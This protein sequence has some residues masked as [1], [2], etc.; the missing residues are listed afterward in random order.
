MSDADRRRWNARYEDGAYAERSH[1]SAYVA[2][3]VRDAALPVQSGATAL[4]VACGAGRNALW[5]SAQ[6][7]DVTGIDI[8]NVAL[9]RAARS[10]GGDRIRWLQRDLEG[11]CDIGGQYDLIVQVRYVNWELSRR[12]PE[13]LTN[14][15]M[16]ICEQHL[17]TDADVIGPGNPAYR[18]SPGALR[19]VVGDMRVLD[20]YE[21][22]VDDP[23]G[24]RA[25]VA[26]VF[27]V[28]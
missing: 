24:R 4:D 8:S 23:D 6:G 28:R 17:Q 27:A 1:P 10:A 12:L 13:L 11:A 26:R 19:H 22:E 18:A 3:C 14:G 9:D 20:Y 5:L 2:Q 25:A 21:G 16:L 15:G 7:F